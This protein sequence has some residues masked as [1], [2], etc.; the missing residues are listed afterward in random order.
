[1]NTRLKWEEIQK[2]YPDQW[3]GLTDVERDG[4]TVVSAIVK[5]SDKTR[6]ELTMMQ[7]DD[8]SLYSCYT[9]PDH[10]APLAM[11]GYGI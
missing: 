7:L 6:S 1:M 11:V 8:S 4:V 10:L 2:K 5:Y 9:C 3:V